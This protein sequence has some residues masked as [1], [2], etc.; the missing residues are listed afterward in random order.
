MAAFLREGAAA[1][2]ATSNF[3]L[4][5]P[6][7]CHEWFSSQFMVVGTCVTDTDYCDRLWS[8][9]MYGQR[10]QVVVEVGGQAGEFYT[11]GLESRVEPA[12]LGPRNSP[13]F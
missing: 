13:F 12:Q 2:G 6:P 11:G 5:S 1:L 9:C 4:D 7:P 10:T 3:R 8:D